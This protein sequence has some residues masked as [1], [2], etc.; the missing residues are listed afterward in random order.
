MPKRWI[1]IPSA[2]HFSIDMN[3]SNEYLG[4]FNYNF[5][6]NVVNAWSWVQWVYPRSG[7]F[8]ATSAFYELKQTVGGV[9]WILFHVLGATAND[10][11]RVRL[12]DTGGSVL[13]DYRWDN[14]LTQ[15]A[16]NHLVVTWQG[17]ATLKLYLNGT[18]TAETSKPTDNS[19]AMDDQIRDHA[20]GATIA[21]ASHSDAIFYETGLFSVVLDQDNVTAIYNDGKAGFDLQSDSG[22]YN[23]SSALEHYWKHGDDPDDIGKDYG[24]DPNLVDIGD[25]ASNITAADIVTEYPGK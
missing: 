20:V 12:T 8:A 15:D 24:V 10:P 17:N 16:W 9:S 25:N 3:G 4:K 2:D 7:V 1:H 19:A 22:N 5:N 13:K 6:A 23:Q 11:F 14:L 21:G 18:L